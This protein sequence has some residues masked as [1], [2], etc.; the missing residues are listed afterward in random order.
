MKK[1]LL[2]LLFPS[3]AFCQGFLPRWE[4]S[5]STDL[6]SYS[7][8]G[9]GG[10]QYLSLAFRPGFYPML[11]VGLSIEPELV[12]AQVSGISRT[13]IS[14]NL[15][16]SYELGYWPVV[17]FVLVGYGIGNSVPYNVANNK[18]PWP[19]TTSSTGVSFIN[20]GCGVKVMT[21]GGRGLLRVEYRYQDFSGTFPKDAAHHASYKD[22]VFG[23][24]LLLGFSVLL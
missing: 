18:Y 16:Y 17:P 2:I 6:N 3:M 12:Y 7:S 14:G 13:N 19:Q 10:A 15:S 5:L 23:R 11:D 20:A 21:F 4:M 9:N 1:I 22:Q 8:D 24:R